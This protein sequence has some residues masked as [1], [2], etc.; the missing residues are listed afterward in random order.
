MDTP[1]YIEQLQALFEKEDLIGLGREISTLRQSFEDYII[2]EERKDQVLGLE[3][4]EKGETYEPRDFKAEKSAFSELYQKVKDKRKAQLELKNAFESENLRLKKELIEKLRKVI[5]SEEN[6]GSAFSAQKEILEEWKK[7]GEI[8]REKRDDIQRD[9]SRLMELFFYNIKIYRELKDHDYKRNHQLKEDVI[10][11]LKQL[12][13]SQQNIRDIENTLKTLQDDWETIGPVKNEEWEELKNQYWE[14]VRSVYDKINAHYEEQRANLMENIQKKR[15]IIEELRGQLDGIDK[16]EKAKDW[17]AKTDFVLKAQENWKT[18]GFGPKKE[19][20]AVWAEFRQLCNSFFDAKKDF[21]R[22]ADAVYKENANKKRELIQ[23]AQAMQDSTEWKTT[24]EKIIQLQKKW[25]KI[26]NAGNR[27]ENKLWAEFRA[28]CDHFFNAKENHFA[29]QDAS[30]VTNLEHKNNLITR[31]ETLELPSEKQEALTQLREISNEFNGIGHVPMK[32]K[33]DVY[34]RFKKAMDSK[35][36]AL[37]LD[38]REKEMVLFKA[39]IETLHSS[40]DSQR[41]FRGER[42]ELRKQIDLLQKEMMTLENNLQFFARSKGADSLKKEVE[43]KIAR[44]G[45]KVKALQAKMK[46][47]PNE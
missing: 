17:E 31:L 18:I 21:N 32:D 20:E 43:A 26:G 16:I 33:N 22:A 9:F 42:Q 41:Q 30:L 19:N 8:P 38:E 7:I 3:A 34:N 46:L 29:A 35:Y 15:A 1:T 27:F 5:E 12:R 28:A 39:K 47:I 45:E 37:N 13:T 2:E 10:F 14:A 44:A 25:K 6:I 11:K 36:A 4:A 40:P 24:A 23:E